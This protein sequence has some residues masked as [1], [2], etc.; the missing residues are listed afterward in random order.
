MNSNIPK[1]LTQINESSKI[2]SISN[3]Q[4]PS[5]S[6]QN[7]F[8]V[9]RVSILKTEEEKKVVRTNVYEPNESNTINNQQFCVITEVIRR[10]SNI[11]LEPQHNSFNNDNLNF[12]FNNITEDEPVNKSF[13]NNIVNIHIADSSSKKIENNNLQQSNSA[14]YKSLIK[15]IAAQLKR[16]VRTPTQ[17]YF[18]FAFQKGNYPL[19]IIRKIQNQMINHSIEFNND[20]F[21]IYTQKYIQYKELVKRIAVLLKKSLKNIKFWENSKY[22]AQ[23]TQIVSKNENNIKSFQVKITQNI[24]DTKTNSSNNSNVNIKDIRGKGNNAVT[25]KNVLPNKN[26]SKDNTSFNKHINSKNIRNNSNSNL[27]NNKIQYNTNMNNHNQKKNKPQTNKITNVKTNINYS[28][29]S[30]SNIG[31]GSVKT[32]NYIN[33]FIPNEDK[34]KP[35]FSKKTDNMKKPVLNKFQINNKEKNKNVNYNNISSNNIPSKIETKPV[36]STINKNEKVINVNV[37]KNITITNQTNNINTSEHELQITDKNK[38]DIIKEEINP[39]QNNNTL[40]INIVKNSNDHNLFNNNSNNNILDSNNNNMVNSNINNI[41]S[42]N[43]IN[44]SMTNNNINNNFFNNNIN[45]N[46]FNDNFFNNNMINKD[47]KS[48]L[49]SIQS[50][51]I[52]HNAESNDI[53]MKNN[54]IKINSD[55]IPNKRENILEEKSINRKNNIFDNKHINIDNNNNIVNNTIIN[56]L[57]NESIPINNNNGLNNVNSVDVNIN[58]KTIVNMNLI[59]SNNSNILG[60]IPNNNTLNNI[61]KGNSSNPLLIRE[62]N[63]QRLSFNSIKS[64]GKKIVIRLSTFKKSEAKPI[65]PKDNSEDTIRDFIQKP[66]STT[67]TNIDNN[68]NTNQN[69]YFS[70]ITQKNTIITNTIKNNLEIPN[71]L[72]NTF[73]TEL[74]KNNLLI[75]D[76]LPMAKD[77]KG[78]EH[79]KQYTFWE[80]YIQYL[81][82]I[83]LISNEKI[84]LFYFIQIIE[85]YFIWYENTNIENNINFK[86]LII[87][88]VNKIYNEQEKSQFLSMNKINNLDELF[89]KYEIFL[90]KN[91]F[92]NYKF[93]KEIEIKFDNCVECNCEL[94]SNEISCMNKVSEINKSLISS[95]NTDNIFYSGII[96]KSENNSKKEKEKEKN[97]KFSESKIQQSF[98]YQLRYV[99]QKIK[100]EIKEDKKENENEKENEI[101]EEFKKPV[102]NNKKRKSINKKKSEKYI[103]LYTNEKIDNYVE[104]EKSNVGEKKDKNGKKSEKSEKNEKKES[105]QNKEKKRR[106]TSVKY[107]QEESEGKSEEKYVKNKKNKKSRK[108][109]GR[110]KKK[111]VITIE[112]DSESSSG[113]SDN[114]PG[115]SRK[116]KKSYPKNA[117][118]KRGKNKK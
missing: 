89:K 30:Q 102:N 49:I 68:A 3:F 42:D 105:S 12:S 8:P 7:I 35:N 39:N 43:N 29:S 115:N 1:S 44:N 51:P 27:T 2:S 34:K 65:I 53:E 24:S 16:K 6:T 109:K 98:E 107:P 14:K 96:K 4:N 28:N 73:N 61:N 5:T 11:S 48:E 31:I 64:P 55:I 47:V 78:Q 84:S 54:F 77:E 32:N 62:K 88:T 58:K 71:S 36:I 113:K 17:G 111:E 110:N 100:E 22:S 23:T 81:Y 10:S 37:N 21:R 108:S 9:N 116:K 80:K 70:N 50:E 76:F 106:S 60:I 101:Q 85:Q 52:L 94:C 38:I 104:I 18:Y 72:I 93:G 13:Q 26:S 19:I 25:K 95:V 66:I 67:T 41:I 92:A 15:K 97:P 59:P 56:N 40:S 112:S 33:P 90:N 87:D 86:K 46:F 20:I 91:K 83:Y 118:N 114:S 75:I 74:S 63:G 103:D 45:N 57:N 79:L 69:I 99:P 82:N 117:K